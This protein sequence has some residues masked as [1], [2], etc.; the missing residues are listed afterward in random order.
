MLRRI[1]LFTLVLC[2]AVPSFARGASV[3]RSLDGTWRVCLDANNV[4][5]TESWF[6]SAL[7]ET[8][9][10]PVPGVLQQAYPDYHGVV[11][12][13]R[14]FLTP[15]NPNVDGRAILRFWQAEYRADVWLNGVS[16]GFHEGGE[17]MFELDVTDALKPV[18]QSNRLTV[19]V[20]NAADLPID[21]ISTANI[22]RRNNTNVVSPGSGYA[23]GGLVDSVELVLAPAIRVVDLHLL[24]NWQTGAIEARATLSNTTGSPASLKLGLCASSVDGGETQGEASAVVEAAPGVS[25]VSANLVVPDYKLW[26]L[27]DPNLYT[28]AATIAD[29]TG[30][31]VDRRA[32]TCGF[33]DFRFER[34][35]FRLNGKRIYVKCSHSGSDSPITHRVPLDPDLYRK[36]IIFS[37]TMGFN[38][39]R[40]IAGMPR[41]FQLDLC[42][43]LGFMVYEECLAGWCY[44]DCPERA[45]RWDAQTTGM[46]LRDRNHPSVVAWGLLNETTDIPLVLQAVGYLSKARELDPSRLI[47]LNSGGF[48]VFASEEVRRAD[49]AIWRRNAG[50]IMP[51]AIKNEK[52]E[53]FTFDG[54]RWPAN[55]FVLHPGDVGAEYSVLKWTAPESGIYEVDALFRDI[56]VDGSAT[57]DIR[58]IKEFKDGSKRELWKG[59]LNLSGAEKSVALTTRSASGPETYQITAQTALLQGANVSSI[60]FFSVLRKAPLKFTI[61]NLTN[62][63]PIQLRA[64]LDPGV[65][66]DDVLA[67]SVENRQGRAVPFDHFM[68]LEKLEAEPIEPT[69]DPA[70]FTFEKG[71]SLAVVVGVG[72]GV[73]TGD[74]TAVALTLTGPDGAVY[75]VVRDFSWQQNP[76]GVWS[77]GW[78]PAGSAPQLDS[79]TLFDV[80]QKELELNPIGRVSNPDS[81]EWENLVADTHPYQ[82]VPHTA[83]VIKTLRTHSKG[84]LPV[85]LSEYGI[86]SAVDLWRLVRLY[87]QHGGTEAADAKH[88]RWRYVNF[89]KDWNRWR[90]DDVFATPSDFFRQAIALMAEQR[91]IGINAIRANANVVA[92]SVTGTHDQGISGE[93]LTTIFRELKPGTVDAMADVFAPLRFCNFVEPVQA[94]VG[95]KVKIE[96][97]LVNEDVLKPG[98]YPVR[99]VVVG[100]NNERLYDKTLTL[101]I[102]TPGEGEDLP[103]VMPALSDEF[104]ID[105]N[106]V[107]GECR[108][109]AELEEGGATAGGVERFYTFD[110]RKF[111]RVGDGRI[112]VWGDDPD[113]LRKLKQINIAAE[114]FTQ[115]DW[116]AA[117]LRPGDRLIVG[118]TNNRA[119]DE[120]FKRLYESVQNGVGVLFLSPDVFAKGDDATHWLP[121]R[122]NGVF[123]TMEHWLYHKDDWARRDP[124]FDGLECGGV[125]DYVYYRDVVPV[126]TFRDQIPEPTVAIAGGFNTQRGYEGGLSLAEWDYGK[127]KI[128]LSTW[129]IQENLPSPIA[130]RLLRNLLN[131]IKIAP[132]Q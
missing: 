118:K 76:N 91:R 95:Q 85:F 104:T 20:L 25:V 53:D 27:N 31:V 89:M 73:G 39:I 24:P 23:S 109:I 21:G 100:P 19:R 28:V 37:K 116:N 119:S 98:D 38:M 101:T 66:P 55:T 44:G 86:G 106:C 127:G 11:W 96:S 123:S 99:F 82:S 33:R 50:A 3:A 115:Q 40:Y 42:D 45:T 77:Y 70:L 15:E 90:L 84:K 120:E 51:G 46:I 32:S 12:Y 88:Y 29:S 57:V 52:S 61:E 107:G 34:G 80:G 8:V 13:E 94:Y 103:M 63:G 14:D 56:V 59:D 36:D 35:Y 132:A 47:F 41:R 125:I 128:V 114:P 124:A 22:P 26:E 60:D 129:L 111:P 102:P 113:L 83:D 6:Q 117:E 122:N 48:D 75:D 2:L 93:G 30:G 97:V 17:E 58:M 18:G 112:F 4:G 68:S 72:D 54:T 69:L 126:V 131:R 71:E 65:S 121:F 110:R 92:H 1:F 87:E 79:F 108:F 16:V 81:Q 64:T 49:Y 74:S 130:E 7:V 5:R 62:R 43:R 105:V 10:I 67:L 9:D 78:L